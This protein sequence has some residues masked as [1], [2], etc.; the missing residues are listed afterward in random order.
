MTKPLL[1]V[2]DLSIGFGNDAPVVQGVSFD[3][4][5]G[6]TLALVGESGSGKTISCRAILRILP[7]AAQIRSGQVILNGRSGG[8]DMVQISERQLRKV[9]GDA[10]SMILTGRILGCGFFYQRPA[11]QRLPCNWWRPLSKQ[12]ISSLFLLMISPLFLLILRNSPKLRCKHWP[13]CL[14]GSRLAC[15]WR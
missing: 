3:L 7:R 12:T 9:R 15:R 5:Q 14:R 1:T 4:M 8:L 6:Q 13:R 11:G 2:D 10:V